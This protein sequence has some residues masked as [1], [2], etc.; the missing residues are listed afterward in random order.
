MVPIEDD[1]ALAGNVADGAAHPVNENALH[2]RNAGKVDDRLDVH[3]RL[4]VGE[5]EEA[6]RP[7]PSQVVACV[8]TL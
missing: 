8:S 4:L 6:P 3:R 2:Y 7:V 5:R 1:R